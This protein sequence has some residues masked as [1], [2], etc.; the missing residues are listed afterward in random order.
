MP[1]THDP[2]FLTPYKQ[3]SKNTT[4]SKVVLILMDSIMRIMESRKSPERPVIEALRIFSVGVPDFHQADTIKKHERQAVSVYTDGGVRVRG[5]LC[6]G[7]LRRV[8]NTK[9]SGLGVCFVSDHGKRTPLS[10]VSCVMQTS[11][12]L[13]SYM[14]EAL[15]HIFGL[16]LAKMIFETG[17]M[18]AFYDLESLNSL[19]ERVHL[20]NRVHRLI[21]NTSERGHYTVTGG[22]RYINAAHNMALLYQRPKILTTGILMVRPETMLL[23]KHSKPNF[24]KECS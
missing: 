11:V 24:F 6:H 13:D 14:T 8:Y 1:P 12:G 16:V 20:S 5:S 10:A 9:M 18:S 3:C 17:D 7:H 23:E 22:Q 19:P 2:V 15:A 21:A 4:C